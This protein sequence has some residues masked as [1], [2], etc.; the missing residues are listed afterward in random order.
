MSVN[1]VI[2]EKDFF[3]AFRIDGEQILFVLIWKEDGLPVL[4]AMCRVEGE[5]VVSQ[6]HA[7]RDAAGRQPGPQEKYDFAVGMLNEI[8]KTKAAQILESIVKRKTEKITQAM[9]IEV[10]D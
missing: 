5:V 6:F 7:G 10:G 9:R 3:K 1:R 8:T 2:Q 4:E